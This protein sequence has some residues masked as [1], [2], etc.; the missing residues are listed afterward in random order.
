MPRLPPLPDTE[1]VL[2]SLGDDPLLARR[3]AQMGI[4]PGVHITVR[5]VG[6]LGDPVELVVE[7]GQSIALRAREAARLECQV[8]AGPLLA[9]AGRTGAAY[10]VRAL[11]GGQA[12]RSRMARLG[13][14]PGREMRLRAARHGLDVVLLPANR[15]VQLGR[16][17][18]LRVIV[19][20]LE[21]GA[22]RG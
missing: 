9:F 22:D 10:R 15:A 18:A 20:P 2:R 3:L 13:L 8:L 21:A 1:C 12:F 14:V 17:E 7:R 16:G 6:P 19:E 4:V 5:R 11:A